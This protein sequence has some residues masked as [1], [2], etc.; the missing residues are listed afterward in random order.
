MNSN[1]ISGESLSTFNSAS[2]SKKA[3]IETE[4]INRASNGDR[5]LAGQASDAIQANKGSILT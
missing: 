2:A 4:L 1:A 3:A 5:K